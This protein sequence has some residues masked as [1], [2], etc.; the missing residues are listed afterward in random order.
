MLRRVDVVDAEVL[1]V[2]MVG[3]VVGAD[4]ATV[5]T[6]MVAGVE[7]REDEGSEVAVAEADVEVVAAVQTAAKLSGNMRILTSSLKR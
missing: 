2:G 4:V 3:V 5:A 7:A 1:G 6:G